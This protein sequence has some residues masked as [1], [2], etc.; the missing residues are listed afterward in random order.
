MSEIEI[1]QQ[2]AKEANRS[3]GG[4]SRGSWK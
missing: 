1:L 3:L 4:R 2:L